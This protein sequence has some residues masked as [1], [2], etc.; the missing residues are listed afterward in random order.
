MRETRLRSLSGEDPWRRKWHPTAVL[1]SGKSHGLKSL[2]GYS[3]WGCKELDMTERLHFTCCAKAYVWLG[4]ICLFLL[5]FLLPWETDL[6][7]HWH[8][9]SENVLP[10]FSSRSFTVSCLIFMSVS[11]F[12]LILVHSIRVC[13]NFTD[14]YAAVQLYQ[15]HLLKRLSFPRYIPAFF[16]HSMFLPLCH[17]LTVHSCV[18]PGLS[19]LSHQ[20]V[21]L[22]F[23]RHHRVLITVAFFSVLSDV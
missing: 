13:S 6:R 19:I 2:I 16:S 10:I 23:C 14:L 17:R 21:P 5:L 15:Q 1:L 12:E 9:L 3:P 4:P 22:F 18:I 11:H 7:K 8:D 20:S